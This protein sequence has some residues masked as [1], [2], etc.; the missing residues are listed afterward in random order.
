MTRMRVT[1][2]LG[3][4]Q[5][6]LLLSGCKGRLRLVDAFED[7]SQHFLYLFEDSLFVAKVGF[8]AERFYRRP[9]FAY[10][11]WSIDADSVLML[12][13]NWTRNVK[14]EFVEDTSIRVTKGMAV[15]FVDSR[16]RP[17]SDWW[18]MVRDDRDSLLTMSN[19]YSCYVSDTWR[20]WIRY[21]DS[22]DM[23][24]V[25]TIWM[26]DSSQRWNVV[27]L[28]W[29]AHDHDGTVLVLRDY[30]LQWKT[31]HYFPVSAYVGVPQQD[32]G[33]SELRRLRVMEKDRLKFAERM[34]R[35]L[36]KYGRPFR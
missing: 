7:A 24:E 22:W 18:G 11:H 28:N 16:G 32:P 36:E 1:L 13:S 25:D 35:N 10:G 29:Q 5:L 30:L 6:V 19:N 4:L 14:W 2:A 3:L 20:P 33:F 17:F 34:G 15:R 27:K 12:R 21:V 8:D 26:P 9:A 23:I 31:D